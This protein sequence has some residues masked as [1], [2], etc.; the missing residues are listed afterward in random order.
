[1]TTDSNTRPSLS[2]TRI[3]LLVGVPLALLFGSS[4]LA[5]A[6]TTVKSWKSGDTLTANDLNAAID[7]LNSAMVDLSS[8]QT[9]N[10]VKTFSKVVANPTYAVGATTTPFTTTS[11]TFVAVPGLVA[12][13][14]THGKPVMITVNSNHDSTAVP[15]TGATAWAVWTVKR[16]G[17]DLGGPGEFGMQLS[18]HY[19]HLNVPVNISFL[20]TPPA[21]IHSYTVEMRL[22]AANMA[23]TAGESGQKQRISAV[24]L[25]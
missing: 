19:L 15:V 8:D 25:N 20:D 3:G 24:E 11:Q 6:M 21:G 23:V 18:E 17:I 5:R 10:G 1:M 9:I 2:F 13:I 16:D 14:T 4:L 22:G 12:T 7:A